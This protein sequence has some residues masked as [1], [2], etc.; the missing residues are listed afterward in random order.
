[1]SLWGKKILQF[2]KPEDIPESVSGF[3]MSHRESIIERSKW[4]VELLE[5][6]P[7]DSVFEI[8]FGRGLAIQM[9]SDIVS[10][11]IVFGIDHSEKM[12][13]S[14]HNRNIE[15]IQ[16]GRVRLMCA[17][18]SDMPSIHAEFDKVLDIN[19]FQFWKNPVDDLKRVKN[20]MRKRGLIALAHQP[21]KPGSTDSDALDAA[22][23]FS[24]LLKKAGFSEIK[25]NKKIIEPVSA[26]CVTGRK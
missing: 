8:G 13:L 19:S 23:N 1:M 3:I 18:V 11:G 16:S 2:G 20:N 4:A 14:A 26:I 24:S 7:D 21:G 15:A 6:Q 25:I 17:S 22:N 5:L 9:M 12:L 10:D